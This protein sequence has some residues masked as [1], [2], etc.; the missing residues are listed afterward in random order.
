MFKREI[1]RKKSAFWRSKL[2]ALLFPLSLPLSIRT[3]FSFFLLEYAF[4]LFPHIFSSFWTNITT[5]S[6]SSL[7]Y[8]K[9]F[10]LFVQINIVSFASVHEFSSS[11]PNQAPKRHEIL[12]LITYLFLST[13][14]TCFFFKQITS[15]HNLRGKIK[16]R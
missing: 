11:I 6:L 13:K 15:K 5:L 4:I 2:I 7:T 10:T 1:M 9:A 16:G 14:K 8:T 12:S 3:N